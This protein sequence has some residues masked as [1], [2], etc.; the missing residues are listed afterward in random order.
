VKK[1]ARGAIPRGIVAPAA[2]AGAKAAQPGNA[3]GRGKAA[4]AK[5]APKPPRPKVSAKIKAQRHATAL[6]AA[7]T[8]AANAKKAKAHP[9]RQLV[10]AGGVA[11]CSAE[12]LAASLRLA[13]WPVDDD[14]VLA[15]YR[16]TARDDDA[17]ASILATLEA[18]GEYGLAGVRL[19]RFDAVEVHKADAYVIHER[20][21]AGDGIQHEPELGALHLSELEHLD[22]VA[23]ALL[24]DHPPVAA[25]PVDG[26]RGHVGR[27]DPAFIFVHPVILGLA[28]PAPHAVLDTGSE[29][30]TWGQAWP[31]EA[32]PDA[33]IEE[34]WTVKWAR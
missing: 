10:L 31:A 14:D 1:P 23:V 21:L 11:C 13:G 3:P 24:D 2:K 19:I 30:I 34:A 27:G 22:D 18:A 29:W 20:W 12:A 32:F 28:L 25:G 9:K 33:V 4:H 8:R 17:G 26:D 15:L 16:R 6:K 5:P 7:K